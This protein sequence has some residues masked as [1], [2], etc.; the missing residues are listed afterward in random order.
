MGV[1][2]NSWVGAI[3]YIRLRREFVLLAVIPDVF[4]RKV[5]GWELDRWLPR[6]SCV[7]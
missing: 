3:I 5:A 2:C 6:A 1:K 7:R 4:S